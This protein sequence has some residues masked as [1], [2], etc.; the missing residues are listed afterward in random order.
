MSWWISV[1]ETDRYSAERVGTVI[2]DLHEPS[3]SGF[4]IDDQP[5]SII[6]YDRSR[7]RRC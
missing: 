5:A 3:F 4:T 7:L 6:S 2:T 1:L